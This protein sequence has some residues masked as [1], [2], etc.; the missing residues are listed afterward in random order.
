MQSKA[1]PTLEAF[2]TA[3]AERGTPREMCWLWIA[4]P[5]LPDSRP[6]FET[7]VFPGQSVAVQHVAQF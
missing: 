3:L 7:P 4:D 2:I 1:S 6:G 5:F